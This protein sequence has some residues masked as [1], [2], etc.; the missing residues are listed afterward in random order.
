M[1]LDMYLNA[2]KYIGGWD[3]SADEEKTLFKQIIQA[4]GTEELSTPHHPGITVRTVVAYWRKV[5]AVHSWFVRELA[6]GVDECQD[7]YVPVEEMKRLISECEAALELYDAGKLEETGQ[8]MAPQSGFFF[9]DTSI[10]EWWAEG[11]K[12]TIQQLT[13]LLDPK[14]SKEFDFYYRASW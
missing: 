4:V 6:N 12:D 9:G 2:E 11:L 10:D 8:R 5:N 13:P 7:I 3:H 1:G 14:I